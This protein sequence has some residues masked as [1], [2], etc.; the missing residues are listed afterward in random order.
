MKRWGISLILTALWAL[1][2]AAQEPLPGSPAVEEK[3]PRFIPLGPLLEVLAAGDLSW[4]PDWPEAFPPDAFSVSGGRALAVTLTAGG[5][6]FCL[7]RDREG[8]L[9]EFPFFF[10]GTFIPVRAEYDGP[11]RLQRL[12]AGAAGDS[13][14]FD[15][16]ENF[17]NPG[18]ADP[19]R[20]NSGGA[21]YFIV[22][23]EEGAA[24]SET[25]YDQAG[26]FAAWYQARIR[27]DGASWRIR[28]LESRGGGP[29][30]RE[31]Y[32]FDNNGR[33]T[34]VHSL[35][36]EF[37][38]Q[39]RD[40][41]PVYWDR[42]PVTETAPEA[43]AAAATGTAPADDKA[44]STAEAAPE[45]EAAAATPERPGTF[46]LQWDERGFLTARRPRTEEGAGE[47][48]YDY[49][50]DRRGNWTRRQDT[51]M[52]DL[53]GLRFPLFRGYYE[54]RIGCLEE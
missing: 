53:E 41:R 20:V 26:D 43:E 10:D 48:R 49:E 15:I 42:S 40:G 24:L 50:N 12:S 2:T 6:S 17:L 30:I 45:A 38:A 29:L 5:E 25:W 18:A 3:P 35:R 37:S 4:R 32:D 52:I 46:T 34:A 8:R 19:V 33:I 51:E 21:W 16:P 9:R 1:S 44:A 54:R 31:D 13:L 14:V 27:R 36:G 7:R 39:Y 23:R 28:S 11:G 47:F 22:I